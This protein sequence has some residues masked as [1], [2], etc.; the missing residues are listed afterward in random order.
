MKHPGHRLL[1]LALL[2]STLPAQSQS[3]GPLV[4]LPIGA[5]PGP[6]TASSTGVPLRPGAVLAKPAGFTPL[7]A[8]IT[9]LS[10][11]DFATLLQSIA[12]LQ[13]DAISLGRDII[14]SDCDGVLALPP[15]AW[16]AL[17][18]SVSRTT[19]GAPGSRIA[20][21]AGRPGGASA[22]VFSYLLPGSAYPVGVGQV[23]RALDSSEL[24]LS[25]TTGNGMIGALDAAIAQYELPFFG[26]TLPAPTVYFSLS[27]VAAN[28]VPTWF[29]PGVPSG[30]TILATSWN[31]TTRK[32]ST[33]KPVVTFAQLGLAQ[34]ED[35]DAIAYQRSRELM[36]FSTVSAPIE[37]QLKIAC[38]QN[39]AIVVNDYTMPSGQPVSEQTGAGT[40]GNITGVCE[41]DPSGD[42]GASDRVYGTKTAPLP[43][44]FP[45]TLESCAYRTR[46]TMTQDAYHTVMLGWP[47]GTPRPGTA[48]L[49][50]D[51]GAG[52]F[53]IASFARNPANPIAG[54]PIE[55]PPALLLNA[56]LGFDLRCVWAAA[57]AGGGAVTVSYPVVL[58]L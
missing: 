13:V 22:D 23:A 5:I 43:L 44:P 18:F 24:G 11:P 21:E 7:A 17:L 33:P 29:A 42:A 31:P 10:R 30:A 48:H 35:I 19:A 28:L 26:S 1:L 49:F 52:W 6:N 39:D 12:T 53:P 51:A 8:P 41:I 25:G 37:E 56:P 40:G 9:A 20:A 57:D 47:S 4:G 32:W 27:S 54:D 38:M 34:S 15:G 14:A 16:N 3:D 45:R 2:A 46:G 55:I 50:L 58:T 36:L